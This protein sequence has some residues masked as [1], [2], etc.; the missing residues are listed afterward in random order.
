MMRLW[1]L[2]ALPGVAAALAPCNLRVEKL[3]ERDALGIDSARPLLSW[4]FE[5]TGHPS[6]RGAL[7]AVRVE[8]GE[9]SGGDALLWAR[10]LPAG[11]T[12]ARF[13]GPALAGAQRYRWRVCIADGTCAAATFLTA[14]RGWNGAAWIAGRQ[15][16]SPT[17]TV[18]KTVKSA[19]VAVTGLGF[20]ELRLNGAKVGD[21]ELDPG[22]STNY[23]E[24][25]L[26]AV[27]D[28]TDAVASAKE[29]VLAARVGAGKY[30][31]AVSHTNTI[32]PDSVF[33]L[34][35]NLE[36]SYSDGSTAALVTDA[37]WHVTDPPVTAEHLYHG[38]SYDAR[39]ELPGWD[40]LGY[41]IQDA[42]GNW[43]A[44]EVIEPPLGKDAVL[45]K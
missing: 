15:L 41:A 36:I 14:P 9:A 29:L 8:L 19:T 24:R 20:Y 34:L 39:L 2:L 37:T 35:V 43:S 22:F 4:A 40:Q 44:A 1:G 38:E 25:V 6:E 5:Q 13:D 33:A 30:S 28:V 21:A 18:G 31:M 42:S 11:A 23:T 10:A 45:V 17:L 26:Y 12:S 32:T 3:A 16:R 7:P 27:H